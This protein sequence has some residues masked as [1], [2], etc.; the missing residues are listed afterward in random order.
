MTQTLYKNLCLYYCL[1]FSTYLSLLIE[2]ASPPSTI[3]TTAIVS[4][5]EVITLYVEIA[6]IECVIKN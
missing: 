3:P 4:T 2:S 5:V 1:H 6:N